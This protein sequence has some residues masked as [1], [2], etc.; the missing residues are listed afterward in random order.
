MI[1]LG[2]ARKLSVDGIVDMCAKK[3]AQ[4][5]GGRVIV[6]GKSEQ[7]RTLEGQEHSG[8]F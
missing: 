4:V 2:R 5:R 7:L 8:V 3:I 1:F 6:L